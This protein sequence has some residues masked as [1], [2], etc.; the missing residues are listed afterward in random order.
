MKPTLEKLEDVVISILNEALKHGE[1]YIITNAAHGWVEY[2]SRK[3]LPRVCK[4]LHKVTIISARSKYEEL[5][6]GKCYKWK[7]HAFMD[8]MKELEIQA[9]TN[10]VA[11]GDSN[12]EIEASKQ[13]AK[14]FPLAL[15][16]TVKLS[17][18]PTPEELVKQLLLVS[19]RMLNI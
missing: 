10:L 9:V 8:T 3:Y 18:G 4:M 14:M 2:S 15:L 12:I 6:P 17:E 11:I 13:L 5:Y 19:N 1:V 7:I 16:K